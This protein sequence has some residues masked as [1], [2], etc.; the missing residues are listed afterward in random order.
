MANAYTSQIAELQ[1]VTTLR[2]LAGSADSGGVDFNRAFEEMGRR[3]ELEL[4]RIFMLMRNMD[5]AVGSG[6]S[7]AIEST[8]GGLWEIDVD[9]NLVPKDLT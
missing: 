2:K 3:I 5:S 1:R 7:N 4:D 8:E 6:I 9:G